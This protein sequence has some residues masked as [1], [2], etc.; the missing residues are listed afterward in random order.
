MK[1]KEKLT[2]SAAV[3][4]VIDNIDKNTIYSGYDLKNAVTK[5]VPESAYMYVD[6][7][8]REMR[9]SCHLDYIL[10]DRKKSLYKKITLSRRE[11]RAE[12]LAKYKTLKQQELFTE[13]V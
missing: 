13:G 12:E 10:F 1:T 8:L 2:A 6:T 3:R 11:R 7:L 5:L 9:A 4:E